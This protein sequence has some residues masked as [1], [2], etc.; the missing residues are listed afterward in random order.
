LHLA[1]RASAR[2]VALCSEFPSPPRVSDTG[3][4]VAAGLSVLGFETTTGRPRPR[5]LLFLNA[6]ATIIV[7]NAITSLTDDLHT[8]FTI[9]LKPMRADQRTD[10]GR[11][12]LDGVAR[13]KACNF[14]EFRSSVLVE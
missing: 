8:A 4:E 13:I 11:F 2:S 7:A 3:G 12:C 6:L 9:G 5:G 10:A 1:Y 14:H